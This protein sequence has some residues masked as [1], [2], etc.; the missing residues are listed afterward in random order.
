MSS[1]RRSKRSSRSTKKSGNPVDHL[2]A[3]SHVA[4]SSANRVSVP[5]DFTQRPIRMNITQS[6][7]KN[8]LNQIHWIQQS[9][10]LRN[11]GVVSGGNV[12]DNWSFKLNDLNQYAAITA[13]FDQFCIYSVVFNV[14]ISPSSGAVSNNLGRVTTAVD[15]DN[16]SNLGSEVALQQYASA[17]TVEV[18]SGMAVQRYVKPCVT[19]DV[20][21]VAGTGYAVARCWLDNA[22]NSVLVPHYGVRVYF[23]I[24]GASTP[25]DYD[26]IAT[27][28]IGCRNPV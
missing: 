2:I 20:Y 22:S 4:T 27:Y 5:A 7:P 24:T 3:R 21:V 17:Q 15:Y 18:T 19:P 9:V 10:T 25:F 28:T 14:V 12:E 1:S 8:L 13:M 16:V 23:Q 6:P 11:G 26:I